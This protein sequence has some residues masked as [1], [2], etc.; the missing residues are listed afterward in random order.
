MYIESAVN[1]VYIQRPKMDL[2]DLLQHMRPRYTI[3]LQ[4][5]QITTKKKQKDSIEYGKL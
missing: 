5:A 4:S 1:Y 2:L 3:H